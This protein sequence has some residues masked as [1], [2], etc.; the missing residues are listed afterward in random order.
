M[1]EFSSALS[2]AQ[3]LE[4]TDACSST[5]SSS[6]RGLEKGGKKKQPVRVLVCSDGMSRGVDFPHATCVVNYD[7]PLEVARPALVFEGGRA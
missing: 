2:A 5:S 3:R 7:A 6:S 4:L 1:G